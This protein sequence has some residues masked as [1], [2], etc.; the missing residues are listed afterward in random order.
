MIKIENIGKKHFDCLH[1]INIDKLKMQLWPNQW[2][3]FVNL[4]IEFWEDAELHFE[5]NIQNLR[6]LIF[7]LLILCRLTLYLLVFLWLADYCLKSG[8]L[9]LLLALDNVLHDRS[10]VSMLR[11]ISKSNSYFDR[12][13]PWS[14]QNFYEIIVRVFGGPPWKAIYSLMCL[15]S[16]LEKIK[17]TTVLL[18]FGKGQEKKMDPNCS[19]QY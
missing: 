19:V 13:L 4:I 5:P 2:K 14:Y 9:K 6:Y 17:H 11:K 16:K 7:S 15:V 18:Q 1:I 8:D 10:V 12:K 3:K